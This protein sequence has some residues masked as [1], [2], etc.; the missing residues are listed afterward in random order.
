MPLSE[1]QKWDIGTTEFRQSTIWTVGSLGW[2]NDVLQSGLFDLRDG[3][4]PV[5][6]GC[7]PVVFLD[8]LEL[9]SLGTSQRDFMAKS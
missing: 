5:F 3:L 8:S 1:L 9:M 4:A 2:Y 7:P 6:H